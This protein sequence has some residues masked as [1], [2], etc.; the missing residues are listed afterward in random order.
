MVNMPSRGLGPAKNF[1]DFQCPRSH[2]NI[3][4]HHNVEEKSHMPEFIELT[5]EELTLV[6]GGVS[7]G[8]G[9]ITGG[10]SGGIGTSVT[11]NATGMGSTTTAT[12]GGTVSGPSASN[13]LLQASPPGS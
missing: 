13:I 11:S 4:F 10:F 6:T 1:L 5:D 7:L 9:S 8:V 2:P 12:N 3:G